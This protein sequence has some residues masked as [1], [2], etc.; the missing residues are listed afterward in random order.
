MPRLP[1]RAPGW[2]AILAAWLAACAVLLGACGP[3]AREADR[4]EVVVFAAASLRDA[5]E[6]VGRRFEE[7]TGI[8]VVFN[9]AGSNVLAQQIVA[10]PGADLFLSASERWMDTVEDAGRLV[11]GTRRDLLSNRLALIAHPRSTWTL[12]DLCELAHL[13]F[14]YLALGDPDAVPAGRYAR[15]WLSSRSCNGRSLWGAVEDRVI[16]APDVR[17]ALG[18]VLADSDLLAVVYRTDWLAF[19][20][21]ARVLYEVPADEGPPIR[22]T[23]AQIADGPHPEAARRLLAYL[24]DAPARRIFVQHGFAPIP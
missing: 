5:L 10:A 21:K 7:E 14:K 9:V 24:T 12:N 11:A 3:G 23:L 20:E 17:S 22:Y 15:L 1:L 8:E 13:D 6:D 4:P 19:A 18:L 2:K 16:P